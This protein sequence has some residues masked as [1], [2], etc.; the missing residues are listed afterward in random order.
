MMMMMMTRPYTNISTWVESRAF[1]TPI[2]LANL[3]SEGCSDDIDEY[4]SPL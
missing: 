2:L 4:Q 1:G 3:N